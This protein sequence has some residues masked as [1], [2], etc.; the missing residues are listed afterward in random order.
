MAHIGFNSHFTILPQSHIIQY[1]KFHD[2]QS[3]RIN[4]LSLSWAFF[5]P[6]WMIIELSLCSVLRKLI[7]EN[8]ESLMK[9][10][11]FCAAL[12]FFV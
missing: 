8:N 1:W 10:F 2:P 3:L 5:G 4:E 6:T 7:K 9:M 12:W 11:I